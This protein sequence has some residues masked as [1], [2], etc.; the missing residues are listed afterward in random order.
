M[1]AL[2]LE[3]SEVPSLQRCGRF[4][5]D[6]VSTLGLIAL[7]VSVLSQKPSKDE[8]SGVPV[9]EGSQGVEVG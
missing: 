5:A 6:R 8:R 7:K 4:C 9:R 3:L 2:N 1:G